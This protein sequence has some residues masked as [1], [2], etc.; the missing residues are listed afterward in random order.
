VLSKASVF[1][2]FYLFPAVIISIWIQ[3]NPTKLTVLLT[4]L[5]VKLI[6][7]VGKGVGVF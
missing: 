1:K 6:E 4:V 2:A 7:L 3:V 5:L